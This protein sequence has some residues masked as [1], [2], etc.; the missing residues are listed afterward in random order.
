MKKFNFS[1]FIVIMLV[2]FAVCV[3]AND[4]M[5]PDSKI[6]LSQENADA[7]LKEINARVRAKV[8]GADVHVNFVPYD[9]FKMSARLWQPDAWIGNYAVEY[10]IKSRNAQ[11]IRKTVDEIILEIK[12][13]VEGN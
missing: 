2:S 3:F 10:L 8:K 9:D 13:Q 1:F 11:Q 4:P 7:V 6:V 12:K 5:K